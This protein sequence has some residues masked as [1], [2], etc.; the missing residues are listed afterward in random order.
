MIQI[1]VQP[2]IEN[3]YEDFDGTEEDEDALL[4]EQG[5]QTDFISVEDGET[6]EIKEGYKGNLFLDDDMD[7]SQY[8]LCINDG[9]QDI[10]IPIENGY[11]FDEGLYQLC[12]NVIKEIY[13]DYFEI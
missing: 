9:S 11:E 1:L 12:G 2:T 5:F 4:F 3:L 7:D 13:T 6:F 10:I 8:K